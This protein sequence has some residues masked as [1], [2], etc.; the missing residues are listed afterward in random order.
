MYERAHTA[1]TL[2]RT[3]YGARARTRYEFTIARRK[4]GNGDGE[5]S[6]TELPK[7]EC[8]STTVCG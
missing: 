2:T 7:W 4:P 6:L 5:N 3:R 1:R 8:S